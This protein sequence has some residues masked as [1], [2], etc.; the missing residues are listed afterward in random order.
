M[1]TLDNLIKNIRSVSKDPEVHKLSRELS[2]WKDSTDDVLTLEVNIERYIGNIWIEKE[3]EHEK[4]YRLWS[5][6]KEQIIQSI[7]VMTVNERL[8]HFGLFEKFDRC[9]TEEERD[10]IYQKLLAQA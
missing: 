4:V 6:F 8:F 5:S 2:N 1:Q 7:G 10:L 3:T 9:K